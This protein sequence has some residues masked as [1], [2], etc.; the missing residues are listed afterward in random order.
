MISDKLK[1][2]LYNRFLKDTPIPFDSVTDRQFA[3]MQAS[4]VG[5]LITVGSVYEELFQKIVNIVKGTN[6][7]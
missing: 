4:L 5:V 7:E 2:Q 1:R 3:E 6:N